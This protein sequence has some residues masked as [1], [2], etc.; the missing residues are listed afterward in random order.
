[1]NFTRRSLLQLAGLARFGQMTAA[2]QATDYKA[3]VCVFLMGGNDGHNMLVP[4]SGA[5][6]NAYKAARG[7]LALPD[8]NAKLLPVM[9]TS[10]IPYALNDGLAAIHPLWSQGKLAAVANVGNIVQPTTRAQY[11]NAAVNVPTNLFSHPDQTVQMQ[12]AVPG[13]SSATGWAG[14]AADALQGLNGSSN[15]PAAIS[16]SGQQLFTTGSVIQSA[17]LIP[18]YDMSPSGFNTWPASLATARQQQLQQILSMDSGMAVIQAANNVRRDALDLSAMLKGLAAST[19]LSTIFPGTQIGQQ[20]KQVAQ[21]MQL[22]NTT[23][24]KR[25]V[26]FCSIGGFDTH[27]S[28]AWQQWDLLK[29]TAAAMNALYQASQEIGIAE[30]VTSFIESEFGRTLQSNGTWSDHGWGNH[31]F[32]MGGAVK[33]GNLYGQFP[34][35]AL[36]GPDDSGNRGALLPTTSLDQYGATL[37]RWF[38]VP[39]SGLDGIFPGLKNF[40]I[41]DL[42]F[43][44]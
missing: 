2:A 34:D 3:L 18:G 29:Q 20:M 31:F 23:G 30:G 36:G 8:N 25:Q 38:G 37:A 14:R 15:F 16:M 12:T 4:Q 1:M 7:G 42:G 41:R 44:A 35:L 11:L 19:P 39:D 17:S 40:A 21:I 5:Q 28:Q 22:R 33:G 10:G 32:V 27:G 26:F 6:F 13:G 43:M 9:P 24:I